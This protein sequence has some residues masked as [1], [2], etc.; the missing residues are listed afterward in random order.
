MEHDVWKSVS[1]KSLQTHSLRMR[2]E[3]ESER[4]K[5][6]NETGTRTGTNLT[7]ICL[8]SSNHSV[9]V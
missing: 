8:F 5:D 9:G 3:E 7:V 2:E 1:S 6:D 4:K